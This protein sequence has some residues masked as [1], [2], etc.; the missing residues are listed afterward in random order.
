MHAPILN[1]E[2]QSDVTLNRDRSSDLFII[3]RCEAFKHEVY[4]LI[5]NINSMLVVV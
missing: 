4:L 5:I 2:K 1:M 3:S